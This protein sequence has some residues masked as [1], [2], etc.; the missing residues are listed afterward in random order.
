MEEEKVSNIQSAPMMSRLLAATIDFGLVLFLSV[1][2]SSLAYRIAQNTNGELKEVISLQS[3]NTSS[4]HLA[5]KNS[6][7][8]YVTY[9]S[10]QYFEKTENGYK[11]IDSLAYFYTVYLAGDSERASSGDIV[12]ISADKEM[13]VGDEKVTPRNYY[14]VEWFNQNV[15]ELPKEGQEAKYNYFTYQKDADNNIDYTKIGTVSDTFIE[16]EV[17]DEQTITKVNPS[18]DMINFIYDKYK[19]A[20]ETFSNQDFMVEYTNKATNINQLITLICRLSFL[21]IF[22]E[23][24]PFFVKRGKT[25]GKLLMRISLVDMQGE[26]VKK[27]QIFVRPLLFF[28]VPL[29]LYF[30]PNLFVQIGIVLGLLIATIV[31]M[32]VNKK[33]HLVIHDYFA[34]TIVSEDVISTRE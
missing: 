5:S 7:G 9:T 8:N 6:Q 19:A 4:T 16:T 18:E 34:R 28:T 32:A 27:W 29:V 3:Q 26:P 23:I 17:V 14:T 30:I 22:F 1:F 25:L 2:G 20:V 15:L 33:N 21:F 31:M 11:I 13:M 10:D 12:S 24:I